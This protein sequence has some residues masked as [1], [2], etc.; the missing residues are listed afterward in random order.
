MKV[1]PAN[2]PLISDQKKGAM[3]NEDSDDLVFAKEMAFGQTPCFNTGTVQTPSKNTDFL[4][5][6]S[7]D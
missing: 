4:P 3:I 2:N 6:K 1:Y 7:H 5:L